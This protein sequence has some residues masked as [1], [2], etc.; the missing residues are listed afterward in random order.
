MSTPSRLLPL[1]FLLI[2]LLVS[3][4]SLVNNDFSIFTIKTISYLVFFN[5]KPNHS[6][7]VSIPYKAPNGKQDGH[8]A[9]FDEKDKPRLW[10]KAFIGFKDID[11]PS[12]I[13]RAISPNISKCFPVSLPP[14]PITSTNCCPRET[15]RSKLTDFKDFASPNAPPR[16]RKPAHLIDEDYIAKLEK[17]IALMKALPTMTRVALFNKL[18]STVLIAMVPITYPIPFRTHN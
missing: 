17:G 5:G 7:N 6:S 12:S 15:S 1:F 10:R 3:L 9:S 16:V 13:S 18:R 4:I 8:V 14:N 11:D 2:V